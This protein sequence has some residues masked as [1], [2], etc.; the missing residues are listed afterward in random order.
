M[1]CRNCAAVLEFA[2]FS[3][4]ARCVHCGAVASSRT[5]D[6]GAD[7]IA[8]SEIPS[9]TMCPRCGEGLAD[10]AVDG[11][12][13]HGCPQCRGMLMSNGA[14]GS[15]VR[16]RRAGFRGA[17]FTPQPVDLEQL[18]DPVSCPSCQRTMEVHPYYGPGNR[19]IDSCYR[20]GVVWIDSGELTAIE[21]APGLR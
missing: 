15:L 9:G 16:E 1:H 17:N 6:E 12:A 10:V 11:N 18:T 21:R 20:C 5:Y 3:D 8:W 2:P 14:F 13:A 7:R 4:V 19:I